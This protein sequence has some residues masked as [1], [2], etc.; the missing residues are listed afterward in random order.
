MKFIFTT[1]TILLPILSLGSNM[2]TQELSLEKMQEQNRKITKLAALELSKSLPQ[3]IDKRTQLTKIE[4]QDATLVYFYEID[5]TPKSDDAVKK[6]DHTR[7]KKNVTEGVCRN[8][9]RFLEANIAIRYI[10]NS[11]NSKTE[12]FRFDINNESCNNL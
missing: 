2:I 12:L 6:E 8:S 11:I 7:M 3:T 4:A 5:A 1:L 9:K 10:Y